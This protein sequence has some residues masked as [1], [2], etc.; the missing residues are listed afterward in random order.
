ML[1]GVTA[2]RVG[3]VGARG[4]SYD[5]TRRMRG[6]GRIFSSYLVFHSHSDAA[7]AHRSSPQPTTPLRRGCNQ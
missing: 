1:V 6:L 7:D 4:D 5:E 3:F 2:G